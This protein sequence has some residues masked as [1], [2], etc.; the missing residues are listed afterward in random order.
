MAATRRTTDK[1]RAASRANGNSSAGPRTQEGKARSCRNAVTHGLFARA[2]IPPVL[3]GYESSEEYAAL[4]QSVR[5]QFAPAAPVEHLL[6][7][8]IAA[9]YWR[10]ARIYRVEAGLIAHRRDASRRE[11]PFGA[12]Q[13]HPDLARLRAA[14]ADPAALRALLVTPGSGRES[15]TD[16][17]IREFAEGTIATLER[18]HQ[19]ALR[20]WRQVAE[21]EAGLPDEGA[22]ESLGRRE[23]HI[24]RQIHRALRTLR[25]LQALRAAGPR[26][27][28]RAAPP[29]DPQE[30]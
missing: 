7:E 23:A 15:Y 29:E 17:M 11:N 18:E 6:V 25:E 19:K 8:S 14:F 5:D 24:N 1:Q 22:A 9:G 4:L 30:G 2:V 26:P 20:R 12:P 16:S 3:E 27:P 13:P 10:L 28:K 21:V